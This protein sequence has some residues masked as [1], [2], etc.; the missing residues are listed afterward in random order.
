MNASVTG[1]TCCRSVQFMCCEVEQTSQ[2]DATTWM[3]GGWNV[4]PHLRPSSA[5]TKYL[6]CGQPSWPGS[7]RPGAGGSGRRSTGRRRHVASGSS[8]PAEDADGPENMTNDDEAAGGWRGWTIDGRWSRNWR[9]VSHLHARSSS[10]H[11]S[12]PLP[13]LTGHLAP[14]SPTSAPPLPEITIAVVQHLRP[15]WVTVYSY[16]T[17]LLFRA[18][19]GL[20]GLVFGVTAELLR[21]E[22]VLVL[23]LRSLQSVNC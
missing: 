16:R 8:G 14:P 7:R 21:T 11:V 1:S 23:G 9:P 12:K 3:C 10:T 20:L 6:S 4:R 13:A 17:C 22:L 2:G 5:M 19:L 15:G 18:T